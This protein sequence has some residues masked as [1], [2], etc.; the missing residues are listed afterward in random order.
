MTIRK[1]GKKWRAEARVKGLRKSSMHCTKMAAMMWLEETKKDLKAEIEGESPHLT[2][3]HAFERYRDTISPTKKGA[4]WET[5]RLNKLIRYPLA[6]ILLKD[7]LPKHIAE[8]RDQRLTEVSGSSVNRELNLIS[9]CFKIAK[10]E[11]HWLKEIPTT[12]VRRPK[13]SKARERRISDD[14]IDTITF[15]LG[16]DE[17]KP[18]E[19]KSQEVAVAFLLAIETAMRMGEICSLRREDIQGNVAHLSD[20]KNGFSRRVPLS[21]RAIELIN[22]IGHN[23]TGN[24]FR[25][26]ASQCS[27]LFRKYRAKTD[28]EDLCFHDTRHEAITRLASKL[29]VLDLAR[30]TGHRDINM[31]QIYYNERP[32][33]IASKLN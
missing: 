3:R 22:K 19:L 9:H 11:W 25:I 30:M 33:D 18:V 12:D 13:E 26:N 2:V 28:I 29:K 15:V 27:A 31:L 23:D 6:G 16:Y 32:E 4:H 20:T 1:V 24:L 8:W 10:T 21:N 5:V 7:L 17:D 14:E